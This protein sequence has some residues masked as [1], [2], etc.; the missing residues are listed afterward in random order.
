[1]PA[2]GPHAATVLAAYGVTL[3]LLGGL[4]AVSLW[5]AAQ[6]RRALDAVE[7]RTRGRRH[8]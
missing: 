3:A 8:G 6:V 7:S 1:M 2:L 5:R 4:V